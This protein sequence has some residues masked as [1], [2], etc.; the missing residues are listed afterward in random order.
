MD[1]ELDPV[2]ARVREIYEASRLSMEELGQRMGYPPK[3]ARGSAWQFLNRTKDPRLSM[4]RKLAT[5][6]R[7]PL[8]A[9]F[10]VRP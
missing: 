10:E 9:L 1:T 6:V 3:S 4:L 8:K 7:F 5:A 2:M